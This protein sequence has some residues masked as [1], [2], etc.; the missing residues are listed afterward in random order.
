MAGR[1]GDEIIAT[2]IPKN[3][4]VFGRI[5]AGQ[6]IGRDDPVKSDKATSSSQS[7]FQL[8]RVHESAHLDITLRRRF[9]Y[10]SGYTCSEAAFLSR[11]RLAGSWQILLFSFRL[12]SS[13]SLGLVLL[14]L[15]YPSL[16]FP[17]ASSFFYAL[18]P[19]RLQFLFLSSSLC[20][21]STVPL[22]RACERAR[23]PASPRTRPNRPLCR[24]GENAIYPRHASQDTTAANRTCQSVDHLR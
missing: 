19:S 10:R 5:G 7:T 8:A 23:A 15:L 14:L 6:R 11:S 4:K 17:L 13:R 1:A 18:S 24:Y 2:A 20:P 12:C 3:R 16:F 21:G 9:V 22:D